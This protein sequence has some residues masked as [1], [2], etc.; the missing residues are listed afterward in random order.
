VNKSSLLFIGFGAA[1]LILL[2]FVFKPQP[3]AQLVAESAA[4][5]QAFAFTIRGDKKVAGPEVIEVP[6]NTDVRLVVNADK[7]DELHLHG[8]DLAL[9]LHP[10][11]PAKLAFTADRSG[12]FEIELHGSHSV[13][14]VLQVQPQ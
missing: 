10:G 13:L 5:P 1:I 9:D 12:R 14:T 6:L 2:F 8:Y 3:P 4:A 11:V 7:A